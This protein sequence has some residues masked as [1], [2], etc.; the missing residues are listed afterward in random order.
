MAGYIYFC[1]I[2]YFAIILSK[3]IDNTLLFKNQFPEN[4]KFD[5]P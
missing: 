1:I 4:F 5:K 2:Y 3:S